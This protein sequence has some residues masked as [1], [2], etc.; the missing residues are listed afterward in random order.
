MV[1]KDQVRQSARFVD[2]VPEADD[3]GDFLQRFLHPPSGRRRE[4]GVA[5]V[6]EKQL[7]RR[8]FARQDLRAQLLEGTCGLLS[9]AGLSRA[10]RAGR[11]LDLWHER[12]SA[13][14]P[15]M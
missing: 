9:I 2:E 6:D 11:K 4:D 1:R 10:G 15:D 8:T 7:N 13:R 14:L 3:E 5:A 12:D